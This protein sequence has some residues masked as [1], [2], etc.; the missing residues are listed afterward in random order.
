MAK[1]QI[2][3][4]SGITRST[5]DAAD[6]DGQTDELIN[7]RFKNGSLRPVGTPE[8]FP[9]FDTLSGSYDRLYIHTNAYRH[10]FGLSSGTLSWIANIVDGVIIP[11]PEPR[12]L[13]DNITDTDALSVT[14]T[15]HLFVVNHHGLRYFIYREYTDMYE[16]I[17][18]DFNTLTDKG[19]LPY[20]CVDFMVD[21]VHDPLGYP[22]WFS[23]LIEHSGIM[24][25][26]DGNRTEKSTDSGFQNSV[27]GGYPKPNTTFREEEEVI[28]DAIGKLDKELDAL[29]L[30]SRPFLVV[31]A[32]ELYDGNYILMSEPKLMNAAAITGYDETP[33]LCFDKNRYVTFNPNNCEPVDLGSNPDAVTSVDYAMPCL[34]QSVATHK[35]WRTFNGGGSTRP[36]DDNLTCYDTIPNLHD[37]VYGYSK[38][39][40]LWKQSMPANWLKVP[41]CSILTNLEFR[42][43]Y[44]FDYDRDEFPLDYKF[45]A[46]SYANEARLNRVNTD[47]PSQGRTE[48]YFVDQYNTIYNPLAHLG[49]YLFGSHG[50]DDLSCFKTA[51]RLRFRVNTTIAEQYRDVIQNISVFITPQIDILDLHDIIRRPYYPLDSNGDH[52]NIVKNNEFIS[53]FLPKIYPNDKIIKKL[54][55]CKTFFKLAEINLE[56]TSPNVWADLDIDTGVLSTIYSQDRL[57]LDSIGRE[58][59]DAQVSFSYNGR[60]HIADYNQFFFDG[61]PLNHFSYYGGAGQYSEGRW[62]LT[63]AKP[64]SS[65][66]AFSGKRSLVGWIKTVWDD[67]NRHAVMIRNVSV[68]E[69]LLLEPDPPTVTIKDPFAGVLYSGPIGANCVQTDTL[70][71]KTI[72]LNQGPELR[73]PLDYYQ[74][75]T[76][77]TPAVPKPVATNE[78]ETFITPAAAKPQQL[79]LR[80]RSI[81]WLNPYLSYPSRYAKSIEICLYDENTLQTVGSSAAPNVYHKTFTLTAHDY[82]NLAYYIDPDLRPIRIAPASVEPTPVPSPAPENNSEWHH[83]RMKVSAVDN[84][85]YFPLE[86]T[87]SIGNSTIQALAVNSRLLPGGQIGD[88]PL[89]VFCSDGIYGLFVDSSGQ[90]TYYNSRP[91][92]LLIANNPL[93]ITATDAGLIFPTDTGLHLLSTI[94]NIQE[95]SETA[96]GEP[97]DLNTLPHALNCLSHRQLVKLTRSID[98]SDILKYIS[99]ARIGYNH[100]DKELWVSNPAYPYSYILSSGQWTKRTDTGCQFVIDYP[101]TYIFNRNSL[102]KISHETPAASTDVALLTRAIKNGT[103]EFK[104][105]ERLI[106]RGDY[107]LSAAVMADDTIDTPSILATPPETITRN[108]AAVPIIRELHPNDFPSIPTPEYLF[109]GTLVVCEASSCYSFDYNFSDPDAL[110]S[111][112]I[113]RFL[114]NTGTLTVGWISDRQGV[115]NSPEWGLSSQN[116]SF[117]VSL[118]MPA[119]HVCTF[120]YGNCLITLFSRNSTIALPLPDFSS[121]LGRIAAGQTP[122]ECSY[123]RTETLAPASTVVNHRLYLYSDTIND[124]VSSADTTPASNYHII[125]HHKRP[126]S[127]NS[128]LD[129]YDKFLPPANTPLI[130][131]PVFARDLADG[132]NST[133]YNSP[134]DLAPGRY[135][136]NGMLYD[137]TYGYHGPYYNLIRV[138][139]TTGYTKVDLTFTLDVGCQYHLINHSGQERYITYE[140]PTADAQPKH[141]YEL[142]NNFSEFSPFAASDTV[143]LTYD[144]YYCVD[145]CVPGVKA[146]LRGLFSGDTGSYTLAYLAEHPELFTPYD[147]A[148]SIKPGLLYRLIQTDGTSISISSPEPVELP[149]SELPTLET[150]KQNHLAGIYLYGSY[151]NRRWA[152][153]GAREQSGTFRDLGLIA[154]HTDCKFFRL[155]FVGSLAHPSSIQYLETSASISPLAAKPR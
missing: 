50:N 30:F 53:A 34:D 26:Y 153:L 79:R 24:A 130:G 70:S 120:R 143:T 108:S 4:L 110:V 45:H 11:L 146:L 49:T 150:D 103:Q 43:D 61:W 127:Q 131:S 74:Q 97:F 144:T 124:P 111:R 145:I 76:L 107:S 86:N 152:L 38:N 123:F 88:A 17:V 6:R 41:N 27:T 78:Y 68:P 155:L 54:T 101:E 8:D 62:A 122:K 116:G 58:T 75:Y 134:L 28:K 126:R 25:A 46:S 56:K 19:L 36:T 113:P 129:L 109:A 44:P 117:V 63:S 7:L 151:D 83:N 98:N 32:A 106:L 115:G 94:N 93:A 104:Q 85:V 91:V 149:L 1:E 37:L 67:E 14:Q 72:S 13:A 138:L 29:N 69:A 148:M 55:D 65:I 132:V 154:H 5:K 90:F 114:D 60:L 137:I 48:A 71:Y 66:E 112:I 39:K 52:S 121:L 35:V 20:G 105:T 15:G 2:I 64:R 31:T 22:V 92:S 135:L 99:G 128:I 42:N 47:F 87:Y 139:D 33:K 141:F 95:L 119:D 140:G 136:V 147:P 96:E 23:T 102:R 100:I 12:P 89:V 84:P 133:L 125:H 21:E 10:L 16:P 51:N 118:R 82:L 77:T 81:Q 73:V 9:G 80:G 142:W 18:T 59:H 3:T 57:H 40:S